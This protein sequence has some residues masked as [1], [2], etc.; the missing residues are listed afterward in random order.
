[1]PQGVGYGPA[2]LQAMMGG[3]GGPTASPST[4]QV[5]EGIPEARLALRGAAPRQQDVPTDVLSLLRQGNLSTEELLQVIALLTGLGG[6]PA[7]APVPHSEVQQVFQQ[8]GG[9]P[10]F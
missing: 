5:V 3:G 1:M 4:H 9:P 6:A 2:V 7:A 10:A 8:A